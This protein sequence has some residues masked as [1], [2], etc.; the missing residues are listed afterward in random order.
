MTLLEISILSYL[1][2]AMVLLSFF[3]MSYLYVRKGAVSNVV[4]MAFLFELVL[5]TSTIMNG[6]DI[7]RGFYE[8]CSVLFIFIVCDYYKDRYY[9][10]IVAF[11]V[12]FSICAYLN[13]LH[14]LMHPNL[15]II[16]DLK[17][18]Q[19]YLLGG[20]YNGM[21]CRLLCAVGLSIACLKYSK[22][23]LLNI[24]PVTIVSIVSLGIV[25]SMTSVTG[26][27]LLLLFCL[28]PSHRLLK[29][30]IVSLITFVIIFQV[31]VCFQGKGIE[32]NELAVWFVEDVLGKDITFTYRTL[33][34]EAAKKV[35]VESP[36]FGYG[37]VSKDWYFSHMSSFALG[38]HNF[39]WAILIFG[40]VILLALFTFICFIVFARFLRV[41][42]KHILHIYAAAAV[43][44]LMMTMEYYP[45]PFI[46]TL[47]SLSYFAPQALTDH[48]T[49]Q[50]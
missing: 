10:L 45:L 38:P 40:G 35:V 5:I 48:I 21:G 26:V 41:K 11:A 36:L 42:D 37:L 28:I 1:L 32:Q 30:G 17:T 24:I 20:N 34:W 27:I 31:F 9:M 15:W 3:S 7:K 23:W 50:E 18:N 46:F 29:M 33:M 43:M 39:I 19:G 4:L 47:L 22:W 12:S 44:F 14:L 2:L 16:D 49:I 25:G 13:F 8:G 6:T